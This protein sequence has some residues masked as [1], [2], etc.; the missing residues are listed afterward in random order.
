MQASSRTAFGALI[1]LVLALAV[2]GS[3]AG[4]APPESKD[5]P[6]WR[7]PL[8]GSH[9]VVAPFRAPAHAYGA[10]HRGVDLKS[11]HGAVVVAPREGIV[12][13]RGMVVDRPLLT[14]EHADGLV[15]TFEPLESNLV[16]GDLISAGQEIGLVAGGGHSPAGALHVGVRRDDDYI[17]PM[18]LFGDVP[19]AILL[20]C[21]AK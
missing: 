12:A 13:F 10:G 8:T 5:W 11:S 9:S 18:L 19:R 1:A 2:V 14:I 4:S 6:R 3:A 20:P 15:S 17:N 21:C 7:W 16:P